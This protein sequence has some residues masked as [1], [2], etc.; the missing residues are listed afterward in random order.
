MIYFL[1]C[2]TASHESKTQTLLFV[3]ELFKD[4]YF[5]IVNKFNLVNI[6]MRYFYCYWSYSFSDAITLSIILFLKSV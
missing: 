2:P 1:F 3:V 5:L 6:A 4:D